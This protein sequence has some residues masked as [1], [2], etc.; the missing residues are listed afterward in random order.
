MGKVGGRSDD[1]S[2]VTKDGPMVAYL[3]TR[4]A[5][6]EVGEWVREST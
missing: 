6:Y 3:M 1:T 2:Q 5:E 4:A